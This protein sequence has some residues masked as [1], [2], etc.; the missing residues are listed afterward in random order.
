[1]KDVEGLE[2]KEIFGG[3]G[4]LSLAAINGSQKLSEDI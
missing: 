2:W 1:M 4:K 3:L